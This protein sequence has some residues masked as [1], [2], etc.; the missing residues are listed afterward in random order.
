MGAQGRSLVPQASDISDELEYTDDAGGNY[1][2]PN[3]YSDG[4]LHTN[5]KHSDTN[6]AD[7][8]RGTHKMRILMEANRDRQ[9]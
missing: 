1:I 5:F 7:M 6:L 3:V 9:T 8:V 4:A 2:F